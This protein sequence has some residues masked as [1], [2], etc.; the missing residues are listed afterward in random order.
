MNPSES[1]TPPLVAVTGV[2][3]V[4]NLG[5]DVE[6]TWNNI[7]TKRVGIGPTSAMEQTPSP[8]KGGGQA[9]DLPDDLSPELPRESRYLRF[10]IRAALA[11]AG[12]GDSRPVAPDRCGVVMGTTLH[13]IRAAG[14]FFL[15]GQHSEFEIFR[16]PAILDQ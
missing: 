9:P 16:G 15:I 6:T 12:L 4:T 1:P 7:C 10:A 13:G 14:R 2:G 11:D 8:D 5:L 3:L